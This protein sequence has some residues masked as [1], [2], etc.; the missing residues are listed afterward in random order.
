MKRNRESILKLSR[1]F[2]DTKSC[3]C[4]GTK[5]T[6]TISHTS[7]YKERS[8][9]ELISGC[10]LAASVLSTIFVVGSNGNGGTAFQ[11][12]EVKQSDSGIGI[13]AMDEEEE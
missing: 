12:K 2:C 3:L 13:E 11:T 6:C 8:D 4:S 5:W 9:Q 10:S 1:W 7:C